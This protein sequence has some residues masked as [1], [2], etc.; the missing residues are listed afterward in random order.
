[1]HFNNGNR[2]L[3]TAKKRRL[4]E[5]MKAIWLL[6]LLGTY[7]MS[8]RSSSLEKDDDGCPRLWC[9]VLRARSGIMNC[10]GISYRCAPFRY[11]YHPHN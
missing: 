3:N 7:V 2:D 4:L 8:L 5:R 1:M 10:T 11:M 6:G 9:R